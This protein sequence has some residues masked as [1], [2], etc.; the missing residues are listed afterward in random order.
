MLLDTWLAAQQNMRA[1]VYAPNPLLGPSAKLHVT[2]NPLQIR[3][4]LVQPADEQMPPN[5]ADASEVAIQHPVQGQ[6]KS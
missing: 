4:E 3:P 1:S 2:L 5:L 6:P